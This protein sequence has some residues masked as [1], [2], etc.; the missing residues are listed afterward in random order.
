MSAG[1]KPREAGVSAVDEA[2]PARRQFTATEFIGQMHRIDGWL[3][4]AD[5][6][7]FLRVDEAQQASGINGDLIEVGVWHGRGAILFHHLLRE[8]EKVFAVDIFDLRD[9]EHRF[10]NDPARLRA[11]AEAFGCDDRLVPVRMDTLR[12]GHR[13]PDMLEGRPV[14]LAHIDGGHDYEV[15][16]RDIEI[17]W[18]LLGKGAVLVFDDFFSPAHAG[19]TQAILEFLQVTPR[20]VPFLITSKKLWVCSAASYATYFTHLK[21]VE[22]VAR[23]TNLLGRRVLVGTG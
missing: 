12:D 4:A 23:K 10:F 14:R 22:A 11:N 2:G 16:R 15:V 5:A 8:S 21:A 1:I 7:W 9:R 19:T 6:A 13:L 18:R 17:V 20:F 3:S